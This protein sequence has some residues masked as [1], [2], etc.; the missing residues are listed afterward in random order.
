[1]LR[2]S[3]FV[4]LAAFS[5][6]PRVEPQYH[7]TAE[8]THN[9]FSQTIPPVLTVASGA[10]VEVFT[11]EAS[12]EQLTVESTTADVGKVDFDPIHLLTGPIAVEGARSGD[13][14]KMTLHEIEV[15]ECGWAG[16][17]PGFGWLADE[18]PEP[19]LKTFRIAPGA[20]EVRFSDGVT[21]PLKPFPGVVGV[22]R[23]NF[24][25]GDTHASRATARSAARRSKRRCGSSWSWS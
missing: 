3:S 9:R 15:G 25:I 7:L 16:V 6:K 21:L 18:F 23:A 22:E 4:A 1:M 24:S 12:D 11:K 20:K 17:F 19:Y 2:T 8:N 10:V 5:A 14:L 13:V